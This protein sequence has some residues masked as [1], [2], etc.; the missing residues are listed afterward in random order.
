[1]T[2]VM[3]ASDKTLAVIGQYA[4]KSGR[5]IEEL[6]K[7]YDDFRAIHDKPD[8]Q[9]DEFCDER[10]RAY[11]RTALRSELASPAPTWDG[12]VLGQ[13]APFD[14]VARHWTNALAYAK[15]ENQRQQAIEKGLIVL[16][17]DPDTKAE[18]YAPVD[19]REKYS[20]GRVNPGFGKPYPKNSYLRNLVGVFGGKGVAPTLGRVTTNNAPAL[21]ESPMYQPISVR[22]MNRTKDGAKEL[23]LGGSSVTEFR[24]SDNDNMPSAEAVIQEYLSNYYTSLADLE[25]HHKTWFKGIKMVGGKK[26]ENLDYSRLTVLDVYLM[27]SVAEVNRSGNYRMVVEDDSLGMGDESEG[28]ER[29]TTVWIPEHLWKMANVRG[30]TLEASGQG[31]RMF[32]IGQ[33]AQPQTSRDFASG[34]DLDVPGEVNVTLL[35]AV[36]QDG[37]FYVKEVVEDDSVELE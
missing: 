12:M 31:T 26:R 24:A 17:V 6:V 29:G 33:T 8:T 27:Y 9:T 25:T 15:D 14:T 10:A 11:V 28:A 5:P 32:L 4:E 3:K 2:E 16:Q 22:L 7:I 21:K 37:Y 23:T 18:Y 34:E 20:T 1:M 35:G 36:I 13:A 19:Q 30:E